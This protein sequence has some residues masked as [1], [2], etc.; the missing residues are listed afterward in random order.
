M[1][2]RFF[3]Q[4]VLL[5]VATLR[6]ALVNWLHWLNHYLLPLK[7]VVPQPVVARIPG[8]TTN[9]EIRFLAVL[10]H[11]K[12][13][14]LDVGCGP[15]HLVAKYKE[16]GGNGIG[17]DA[18]PWDGVD[19]VANA[20][21]LPLT[22]GMFDT[23]SFVGSLNHIP[24]REEALREARRLLAPGGRLLITMLRPG[25]SRL[26]HRW[27]WWDAD[28]HV[29]GM[30]DG[31]VWG[32]SRPDLEALLARAGFEVEERLPF[33]WGLNELWSCHAKQT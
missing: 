7:L 3:V 6:A 31:E 8:L 25:L 2:I 29:R 5:Y 24:H 19:L 27:A 12:G 21:Y 15:N 1:L 30:K 20:T 18:Y 10:P 23:V 4:H 13:W 33:S 32:L 22:D 17:V 9:E 28:Q 11:V 14:L 16:R 26:W